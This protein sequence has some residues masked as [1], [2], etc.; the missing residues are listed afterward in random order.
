MPAPARAE[1]QQVA[2]ADRV[3]ALLL[4][5]PCLVVR[6]LAAVARRVAR[7]LP[8]LRPEAGRPGKA[9]PAPAVHDLVP[10]AG[11]CL[12]PGQGKP[13]VRRAHIAFRAEVGGHLWLQPDVAEAARIPA[14]FVD[15]QRGDD[16]LQALS[17]G[18]EQV[19]NALPGVGPGC[20][21]DIQHQVG[22]DRIGAQ[23]QRQGDVVKRPQGAGPEDQRAPSAEGRSGAA[24][25]R[26]GGECGVAG[27]RRDRVCGSAQRLVDCREHQVRVEPE[28]LAAECVAV[29]QQQ[30]LRPFLHGG[31]RLAAQPGEG[32]GQRLGAGE[33]GGDAPYRARCRLSELRQQ[34]AE[35]VGAGLAGQAPAVG[36]RDPQI[37]PVAAEQN[38]NAEFDPGGRETPAVFL[39]LQMNGGACAEHGAGGEVLNL[40]FSV[41]RRVGHHRH[42]LLEV[43]CEVL[44][45]VGQTGQRAVI[46]ERADGLGAGGGHGPDQVPVLQAPPHRRKQLFLRHS[47]GGGGGF[48]E[49]RRL[50]SLRPAHGDKAPVVHGFGEALAGELQHP[51]L[52]PGVAEHLRGAF[53]A[54]HHANLLARRKGA[55]VGCEVRGADDA[56]LRGEEERVLGLQLPEGAQAHGVHRCHEAVAAARGD[57]R[58]PLGERAPG[59]TVVHVQVLEL[60]RHGLDLAD[61]GREEHLHGFKEG[62][63]VAVD[64]SLQRAVEVLRVRPARGERNAHLRRLFPQ[65][66][67]GV[68]LAV[69]AQSR[70]RLHPLEHRSGVR[71]V[72]VV[73]QG[74]TALA[75]RVLQVG[76]VGLEHVGVAPHLVHHGV[77]REGTDVQV[78]LRL[79]GDREVEAGPA[80]GFRLRNRRQRS[81]LPELGLPLTPPRTQG[82]P[83]HGAA[84]PGQHAEALCIEAAADLF[85][86]RS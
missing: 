76:V 23:A 39:A 25:R 13:A 65:G 53:G 72:P 51:V 30:H 58:G 4:L 48:R 5:E 18:G 79:Q 32:V 61:D 6:V 11:V 14:Q 24:G 83:V 8:Q 3:L 49:A 84:P 86:E 42:G 55:R 43:V 78:R 27:G 12:Q 75:A 70:E 34:V 74:S 10:L 69:V 46:P 63:P 59:L 1:V 15:A 28:A 47:G 67:D 64:Q 7:S 52:Q 85:L 77:R 41:H 26:C 82:F 66:A 68:D 2:E 57:G 31:D 44:A 33:A 71:G 62:D 36:R 40:P 19:G 22:V 54:Q 60:G 29:V 17:Q 37:S 35:Q 50:R 9:P 21:G 81:H 73:P 45:V 20:G 16:L 56:R 38:G 80:D